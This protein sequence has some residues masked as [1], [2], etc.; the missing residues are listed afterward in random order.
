M[1]LFGGG[2]GEGSP[3]S[4]EE[5][6][7]RLGVPLPGRGGPGGESEKDPTYIWALANLPSMV[8]VAGY[9]S[10][11]PAQA[12]F[13]DGEAPTSETKFITVN[14]LDELGQVCRVV[15]GRFCR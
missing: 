7:R 13:V 10:N 15:T 4:F 5:F 11:A 12:N 8:V 1:R 14:S 2:G 6:A 3:P 9:D